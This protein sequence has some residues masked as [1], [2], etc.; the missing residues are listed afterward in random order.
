MSAGGGRELVPGDPFYHSAAWKKL[1]AQTRARWKRAGLP[2]A[3]C[4]QP[5]TPDQ[6][7]IVDHAIPRKDRPDLALD[8][9]NMLVMHH[10]CHSRKTQHVDYSDRPEI[11][12]DGIP[13][14]SEWDD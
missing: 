4:N 7:T 5:I 13:V 11:N 9:G 2:C 1:R 12:A 14:G 10:A 6:K 3:W 8:P